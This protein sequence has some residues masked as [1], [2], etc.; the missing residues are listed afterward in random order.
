MSNTTKHFEKL[1]DVVRGF[2]SDVFWDVG[3][4]CDL[5]MQAKTQEKG[6][7]LRKHFPGAKWERYWDGNGWQWKGKWDGLSLL[8]YAID[9]APATC[10]AIY[11]EQTV[12]E[13]SG[14]V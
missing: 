13:R 9:D 2:D 1:V 7:E 12:I 3:T 14:Y 6:R 11:E 8:I 10:E 5:S 4:L